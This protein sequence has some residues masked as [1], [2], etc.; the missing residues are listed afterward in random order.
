MCFLP[1]FSSL[2]LSIHIHLYILPHPHSPPLLCSHFYTN[3]PLV[4]CLF[5]FFLLSFPSRRYYEQSEQEI[6]NKIYIERYAS[7]RTEGI[8]P[9]RARVAG[10]KK[11]SLPELCARSLTCT[12]DLNTG[13]SKL[14]LHLALLMCVIQIKPILLGMI[15]KSV[16]VS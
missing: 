6:E 2:S 10:I 8:G 9:A 16:C 3:T 5:S 15:H 14:C 1:C 7:A 4:F 11:H 13:L 12:A